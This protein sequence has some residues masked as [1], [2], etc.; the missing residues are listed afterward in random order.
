MEPT[1]APDLSQV[2]PDPQHEGQFIVAILTNPCLLVV[3]T[4]EERRKDTYHRG[5]LSSRVGYG[6]ERTIKVVEVYFALCLEFVKEVEQTEHKGG[7]GT[8]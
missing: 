3:C 5:L 4:R 6:D 2:D 7:T 8:G 1:S